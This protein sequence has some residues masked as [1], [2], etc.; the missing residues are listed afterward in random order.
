VAVVFPNQFG[1]ADNLP[2]HQVDRHSCIKCERVAL[3][4]ASFGN[5][6]LVASFAFLRTVRPQVAKATIELD[7]GLTGRFVKGVLGRAS[8]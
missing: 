6:L 8:R 7:G 3:L 5:R 4:A 1:N 2:R